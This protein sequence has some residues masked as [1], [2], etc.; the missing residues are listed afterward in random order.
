MKYFSKNKI[1]TT[2]FL[3]AFFYALF[4][5]YSD[6][7]KIGVIYERVNW[8]FLLPIFGILF[9]TVFVRSIIQRFL[10]QNIGIHVTI[11]DSFLIF[12]SGLSM[13]ITPGGSG[14][15]VK[16]YFIQKKFGHSAAK[17]L[18]IVFVERFFELIGVVILLFVTLFFVY[19]NESLIVAMVASAIILGLLYL[20]RG[21]KPHNFL[22]K[23]LKKVKPFHKIVED[24]E[25]FESMKKLFRLK[26]IVF[27]TIVVTLVTFL[28][29]FMFYF[30]FLAF[31]VDLGYFESIQTFYTSILFGSLFF[32]PGGVGATEGLF[33]ALLTQKN[34]EL[35]LATSIIL[36]LRLSTIWLV[37]GVGFFVAY[38]TFI[39][40]KESPK[41]NT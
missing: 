2:I 25:L 33:A 3:I 5:L 36:F 27:M 32:I 9:F 24:T 41:N 1:I 16:S 18:P 30:G 15:L 23:L 40:N 39:R 6:Y 4:T 38:F 34:I 10:L 35:S 8:H 7:E 21:E 26:V 28:E 11:K 37:T 22:V 12:L 14:V 19:T 31:G 13:I 29:A 20:V 17:S